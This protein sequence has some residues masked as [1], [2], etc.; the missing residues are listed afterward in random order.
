M[1]KKA[2]SGQHGAGVGESSKVQGVLEANGGA[3]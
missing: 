3:G 1:A 2:P